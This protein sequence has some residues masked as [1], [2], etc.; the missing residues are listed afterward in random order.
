[1]PRVHVAL[2]P[3]PTCAHLPVRNGLVNEVKFLGLFPKS[4][5]DQWDCEIAN[6]STS[7]TVLKFIHLHLSIRFWA[8]FRLNILNIAKLHCHKFDLIHLVS[9]SDPTLAEKKRG[10]VTIRHP[11]R[12]LRGVAK[13]HSHKLQVTMCL[14]RQCMVNYLCHVRLHCRAYYCNCA[15]IGHFTCQTATSLGR[16]GCRIVTNPLSIECHYVLR[17][18]CLPPSILTLWWQS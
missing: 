11:A 15:V 13:Y 1:M 4:S 18:R 12:P 3:V 2:S 6:Y 9:Y 10:L 16:V 14:Y 8:G 5:Q 7:L 17:I